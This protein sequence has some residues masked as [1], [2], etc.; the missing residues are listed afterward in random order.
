MGSC[1]SGHH[2]PATEAAGW[3]GSLILGG[4]R[5]VM[6]GFPRRSGTRFRRWHKPTCI[7]VVKSSRKGDGVSIL[8]LAHHLSGCQVILT[9]KLGSVWHHT[10]SCWF[11]RKVMRGNAP[12]HSQGQVWVMASYSWGQSLTDHLAGW[13]QAGCN[14]D[15]VCGNHPVPLG[16]WMG[17][18]FAVKVCGEMRAGPRGWEGRQRN[19]EF[20]WDRNRKQPLE[21]PSHIAFEHT[22]LLE[23]IIREIQIGLKWKAF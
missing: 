7:H 22:D 19:K 5:H 6:Q 13:L 3:V 16:V 20:I 4:C 12:Q 18:S 8:S 11:S 17:R 1:L 2:L 23:N 10:H 21:L 9:W 15:P 14:P